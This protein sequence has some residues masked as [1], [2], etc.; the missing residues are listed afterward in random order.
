LCLSIEK[1]NPDSLRPEKGYTV[2]LTQKSWGVTLEREVENFV[3]A[4]FTFHINLVNPRSEHE[5]HLRPP[6]LTLG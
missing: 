4:F 6:G 2:F 1:G 3:P 5:F